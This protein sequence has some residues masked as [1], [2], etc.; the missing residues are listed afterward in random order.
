MKFE[1][2]QKIHLINC[3]AYCLVLVSFIVKINRKTGFFIGAIHLDFLK[4]KE[5]K[6]KNKIILFVT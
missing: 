4:K 1:I 2:V 6:N 3:A 5:F